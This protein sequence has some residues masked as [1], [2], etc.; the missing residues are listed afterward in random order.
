MN[1]T[2]D[3][4]AGPTLEFRTLQEPPGQE[5]DHVAMLHASVLQ[6]EESSAELAGEVSALAAAVVALKL[7]VL[8]MG[9]RLAALD[10]AGHKTKKRRK[11][12]R[13]RLDAL[14]ARQEQ[15]AEVIVGLTKQLADCVE[16]I[17]G[18]GSA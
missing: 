14:E 3:A 1:E 2:P 4:A 17:P 8:T 5:V 16:M 11:K 7:E 9:E 12:E 18:A 13:D 10:G 15:A 6:A